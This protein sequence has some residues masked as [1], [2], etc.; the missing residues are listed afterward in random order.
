MVQV[1]QALRDRNNLDTKHVDDVVVGCVTQVGDQ[2]SCIARTAS[3]LAGYDLDAPG[4]MVNRFCGSGL[5]AVNHAATMVASGFFDCVVAGGVE[6]MS[7]VRMGSDG[8]AMFEPATQWEVGAVPQGISADL[9]ATLRG[10]KHLHA[11][12]AKRINE[13]T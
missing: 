9:L 12:L 8:G 11:V 7:R 1:L 3:M 4:V 5:E 13:F 6:S 10:V 2:G